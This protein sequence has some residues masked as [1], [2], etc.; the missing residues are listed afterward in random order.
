MKK[1]IVALVVILVIL[2]A[3]RFIPGS[4]P[5]QILIKNKVD[6][7]DRTVSI[8]SNWIK[9][10]P[11]IKAAW[12][13]DSTA[14]RI[15]QDGEGKSFSFILP[16]KEIHVTTVQG[17]QYHVQESGDNPADFVFSF[18]PAVNETQS[19]R[20]IYSQQSNM[21]YNTF[22]FLQK[23]NSAVSIVTALKSY[24][25][26][27][28]LLYGFNITL[29]PNE[30]KVY[31]VKR[32]AVTKASVY[33]NLPALFADIENWVKKKDGGTVK[34]YS[35][36]YMPLK[37][38]STEIIAGIALQKVIDGN[39]SIESMK[40]PKGQFLLVG[41][42]EGVYA[43]RNTLY[44]AMSLYMMDKQMPHTSAF[45]ER[46][47]P[48]KIPVSDSSIVKMQLCFPLYPR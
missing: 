40:I 48:G 36:S 43:K 21:L 28:Q 42:Y 14:C 10:H 2:I 30:E 19:T 29:H 37:K 13:K 25:E 35:I 18:A 41:D 1:I 32:I 34:N 27:V 16:G 7:V 5:K 6:Q 47:E 22:S 4:S 44:A 23:N 12:Q 26:D 15:Q 33:N 11:E 31:I 9:W 20:L 46:F 24:L 38:D 3:L 8:P 39:D 17:L 45:F